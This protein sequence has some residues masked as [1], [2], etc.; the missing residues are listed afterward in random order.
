MFT[1]LASSASCAYIARRQTIQ[2]APVSSPNTLPPHVTA[3]T[4][5]ADVKYLRANIPTAPAAPVASDGCKHGALPKDLIA[6][7]RACA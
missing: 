7:H 1:R 6:F 3:V 4:M 5:L 2:L